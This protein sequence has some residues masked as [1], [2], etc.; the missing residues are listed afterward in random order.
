[1]IL[2]HRWA[3]SV[4]ALLA[5]AAPAQQT[6]TVTG[7]ATYRER[8]A[9]PPDAVFEA[10]LEDVS[11]PGASAGIIGRTRLEKPGQPPFKFSIQ[12]DPARIVE[13]HPYSVRA[14]VTAADGKL[15]FITDQSY[16][17]LTRGKGNEVSMMIMRRASGSSGRAAAGSLGALPAS[18]SGDL[19][20]ADCPGIRYTLNLFPDRS[21]YIR[22]VYV[23]RNEAKPLDDIGRWTLS[24]DGSTL[25]LKGGKESSERYAVKGSDVLRKLDREGREIASQFNYDLRRT[26]S[27]ERI[28]PRLEMRGMFRYMAD[29]ATFTECQTGQRWP[30]VMEGDYQ[31]LEGAYLNVK[32]QPAE[33]LLV[34]LDGQVAMRPNPDTRQPAPALI[35]E[36]YIGIWP[37][38]TCGAPFATSPLQET[39][40]KLT[41]LDGKPVILAEK[42]REP[43][44]IIRSEQNRVTGFGGCNNF[45]GGYKLNGGDITFTGVAATRMACLQGMDIE[46]AL[47]SALEK[48]RTWKISGEHLELFDASGGVLARFEARALK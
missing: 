17:V 25:T 5:P 26:P 19:P 43:S 13:S 41:R 3:L 15:M 11:R 37:G 33:E 14:R 12:Y 9:L 22:M 36:R 24:S 7:T 27:F 48:V 38:E 39:Y 1:M 32:R 28:E 44:L 10:T 46:G 31:P 45:T 6:N 30:V 4:L 40:W 8:I 18:F 21:F 16:P 35:V 42:Q 23:G 29:A 34:N 47:F 20:C 2:Q